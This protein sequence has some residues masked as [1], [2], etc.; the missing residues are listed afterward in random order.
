MGECGEPF[1]GSLL[2][3]DLRPLAILFMEA[4]RTVLVFRC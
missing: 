4:A 1:I 3:P 2:I